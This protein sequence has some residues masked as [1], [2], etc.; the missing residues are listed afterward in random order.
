MDIY[1][2]FTKDIIFPRLNDS[3]MKYKTK[4]GKNIQTA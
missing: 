3:C 1:L 2:K 4:F